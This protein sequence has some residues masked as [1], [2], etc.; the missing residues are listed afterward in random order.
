VKGTVTQN[1]IGIQILEGTIS[2]NLDGLGK[3]LSMMGF[4]GVVLFQNRL[5]MRQDCQVQMFD[6]MSPS[7]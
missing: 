4:L 6:L 1:L 7:S 2:T 3:L 5:E